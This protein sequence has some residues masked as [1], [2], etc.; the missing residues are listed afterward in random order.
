MLSLIIY[1]TFLY[2]CYLHWACIAWLPI[3]VLISLL[4]N[5]FVRLL[6]FYDTFNLK[7]ER[8]IYVDH[9]TKEATMEIKLIFVYV[10]NNQHQTLLT[11][12]IKAIK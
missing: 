12:F 2:A 1:L 4:T 10:I 3:F 6:Q 8:L 5:N 11:R 9:I 7:K